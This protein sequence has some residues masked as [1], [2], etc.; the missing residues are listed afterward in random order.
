[1]TLI[2]LSA[3]DLILAATALP[4]AAASGYLAVLAFAARRRAVPEGVRTLRFDIIVPAHN[5]E[6]GIAATVTN[7]LA[8]DYPR[9]LYRVVVVADNC[10]DRTSAVARDAG[11]NVLERFDLT[12]RGKGFALALAFES[13]LA[14]GQASAVVVVDA[15]SVV[16]PNFLSAFAARFSAGAE[17]VQ[18]EYGV[19]NAEESWRTR[20]MAIAFALYHTLR[21]LGR[22]RLG[23]SC[24]LRGNGMGFATD[25]LRRVPYRAFSVVEDVEFGILLGLAGVRVAYVPEA[26]VRGEMP[27]TARASRTQRERWEGGRAALIRAHG[28]TL[29]RAGFGERGRLALDLL[30]DLLVPPLTTL[31]AITALGAAAAFWLLWLGRVGFWGVA[32]WIFALTCIATYVARGCALS[33]VGAR[34]A[35]DLLWTPVYAVWKLPLLFRAG[36]RSEWIRTERTNED[37]TS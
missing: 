4:V 34:A 36:Q 29:L 5:E 31:V 12:K 25:V 19:R 1:M 28:A 20:L 27:A 10:T 18:G 7:L 17:C 6:A 35:I 9:E 24:G 37:R 22:E 32:G 33:G 21:S 2:S 15:D 14:D 26:V 23:F 8:L 3:A 16:S 11:A 30:A 13:S